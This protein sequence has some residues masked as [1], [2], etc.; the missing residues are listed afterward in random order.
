[1]T[2]TRPEIYNLGIDP[3]LAKRRIEHVIEV[4]NECENA[5]TAGEDLVRRNL[6]KRQDNVKSEILNI[7][8]LL[9]K[10]RSILPEKRVCDMEN[11]RAF[12]R[13]T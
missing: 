12:A 2:H 6:I 5:M 3:S 13:E 4:A 11:L 1:M 10:K 7:D 8:T 9:G